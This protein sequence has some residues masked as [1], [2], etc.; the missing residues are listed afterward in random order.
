MRKFYF[1]AA[2]LV[3]VAT[4]GF[5]FQ[6]GPTALAETACPQSPTCQTACEPACP[7]CPECVTCPLGCPPCPACPVCPDCP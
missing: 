1:L 5:A 4:S 2:A 3:A 6:P 7:N